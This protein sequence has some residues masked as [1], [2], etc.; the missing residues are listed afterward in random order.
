MK[1][2]ELTEDELRAIDAIDMTAILGTPSE[3]MKFAMHKAVYFM[4]KMNVAESACKLAWNEHKHQSELAAR[5]IE[6]I[7]DIHDDAKF[8][9]LTTATRRKIESFLL[10]Y[11]TASVDN[12]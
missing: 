4:R 12:Q 7:K 8:D 11:V 1:D 5:A 6:L 3:R 2:D 9:F 10:P